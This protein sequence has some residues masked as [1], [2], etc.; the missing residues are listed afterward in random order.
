MLDYQLIWMLDEFG[1]KDWILTKT[2]LK[3]LSQVIGFGNYTIRRGYLT[4]LFIKKAKDEGDAIRI[5]A[6]HQSIR[7]TERYIQSLLLEKLK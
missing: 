2:Q 4:F 5:L 1:W 7:N 3:N 6:Q